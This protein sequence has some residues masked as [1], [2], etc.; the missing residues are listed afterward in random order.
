MVIDAGPTRHMLTVDQTTTLS[1]VVWSPHTP[2]RAGILL[3]HGYGEHGE[4]LNPT[5]QQLTARGFLVLALDA[6]G[7]GR[8]SGQP[9]HVFHFDQYVDDL[10]LLFEQGRQC[11]ANYVPPQLR[12]GVPVTPEGEL[13]P[14]FVVGHSLGGLIGLR[15]AVRQQARLQ[16]IVV[17]NPLMALKMRVPGYKA[18]IGQLLSSV[19]PT[20]S[21]GNELS[22]EDMSRDP[23]AVAA[24]RDDPLITHKASARWFT[25]MLWATRDTIE[26]LP[27]TLQLPAL[28]MLSTQDRV[29]DASVSQK[30][31]DALTT[32]RKQLLICDGMYHEIFADIGRE[33]AWASLTAWLEQELAQKRNKS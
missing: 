18:S 5:A 1:Y 19:W 29:V 21:L 8:S 12:R 28:F 27:T 33:Q 20:F 31:Y 7:H 9:G 11:W 30:V 2:V 26:T 25:E 3:H 15:F 14:W 16:G 22:A 23:V 6:R 24:Y 13:A 17:T 32:P 4:R 10:C